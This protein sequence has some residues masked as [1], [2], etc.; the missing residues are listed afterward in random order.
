MNR[1]MYKFC[2]N[3]IAVVVLACSLAMPDRAT[4]QDIEPTYGRPITGRT[5]VNFADGASESSRELVVL[6]IEYCIE[7]K[8]TIFVQSVFS[9]IKCLNNACPNDPGT[10]TSL[11]QPFYAEPTESDP[12]NSFR[13]FLN[14][15][16]NP[17]D[18]S[19]G[20]NPALYPINYVVFCIPDYSPTGKNL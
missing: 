2:Y 13:V 18:V 14:T 16:G 12:P 4:A 17:A 7:G 8:R 10:G 20:T 5:S 9:G 11:V 6:P 1:L 15:N 3:A 19:S